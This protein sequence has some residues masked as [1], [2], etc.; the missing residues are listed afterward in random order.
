MFRIWQMIHPMR[1]LTLMYIFLALLAFTI[2]FIL[3]STD[4]Y[5]WLKD[6]GAATTT[7]QSTVI[8]RIVDHA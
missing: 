5:N 3:L 1:A 6:P 4:R 8:E 2:H 7:G